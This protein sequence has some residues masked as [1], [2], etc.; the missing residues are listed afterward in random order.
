[1]NQKGGVGK[2]TT[3]L[4]LAHAMAK[5]G[6]RVLLIDTDPQAHLSASLGMHGLGIQGTDEVLLDGTSIDE[7]MLNVRE[8]LK[9]VPAGD[10]LGELEFVS[11]G[12]ASRGYRL[13]NAIA[14]SQREWDY[15][16][17]DCPPSTGLLGMNCLLA[18]DELL[19]PISSDYLA[20]HGLSRLIGIINNIESRLNR[21]TKKWMV[22]TRFQQRRKLARGVMEKVVQ[23]FPGQVLQTVIREN[24]ALAE[25]PGFGKTIFDYR[26]SSH[27]AEDYLSLAEDL[28]EERVL[29]EYESEPEAI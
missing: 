17:I 6:K 9:L 13:K 20:L 8:G 7:V 23:H 3:S 24:V 1:M 22:L 12:G 4:N 26:K 28:I 10:R 5:N 25:S 29:Y 16:I 21:E 27:G 15:I 19:I 11:A 14:A 2:T 18:A